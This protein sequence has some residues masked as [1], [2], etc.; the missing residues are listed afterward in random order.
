[1]LSSAGVEFGE[2]LSNTAEIYEHINV[3]T[4]VC[5]AKC[6]SFTINESVW[7]IYT[8]RLTQYVSSVSFSWLAFHPSARLGMFH[9]LLRRQQGST[10]S[11]R[12]IRLIR[13]IRAIPMKSVVTNTE[14]F[15]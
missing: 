9:M 15:E 7:S 14:S 11:Q 13:C 4:F 10:I 3:E 5:I 12:I 2:D 6:S 8:E 1:M